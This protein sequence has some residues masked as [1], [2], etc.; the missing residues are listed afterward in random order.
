V[1]LRAAFLMKKG[2][3][4]DKRE[5]K[6]FPRIDIKLHITTGDVISGEFDTPEEA[7]AF[8]NTYNDNPEAILEKLKGNNS[9]PGKL[10]SL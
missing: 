9:L 8:M 4:M 7:L 1:K 10:E 6:P 2:R 3:A 5:E